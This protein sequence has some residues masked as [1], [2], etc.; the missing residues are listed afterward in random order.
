M[1]HAR[2]E[3]LEI[4]LFGGLEIS[5]SAA[6]ERLPQSKKTRALLAYL[7]LKGAPQRRDSLCDWLWDVPDDPR[8]AL[9]WSLSKLRPLVND[10]NAERLTADRER[11]AF[12]RNGASV[13]A[14]RLEEICAAGVGIHSSDALR[15]ALRRCN[16]A[17]LS[18]LD[19]PNHPAWEAWRLAQQGRS[20]TSGD[21]DAT[22]ERRA[23]RTSRAVASGDPVLFRRSQHLYCVRDCG[24]RSSARRDGQLAESPRVRL[25]EPGLSPSLPHA[26]R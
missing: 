16:G 4:R 20:R 21:E 17:L 7:I 14:L 3:S 25:G 13:D 5:R 18:G 15:S 10:P 2:R 6:I 19:L 8:G 26:D 11:V 9:R 24:T 1:Q 22:T 23:D 12:E